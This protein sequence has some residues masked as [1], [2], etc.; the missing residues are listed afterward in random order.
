MFVNNLNSQVFQR[1]SSL[2]HTNVIHS[3]VQKLIV[4]IRYLFFSELLLTTI[5]PVESSE[6]A[7]TDISANTWHLTL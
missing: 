2:L 7:N 5:F 4:A 6:E 3:N 1:P